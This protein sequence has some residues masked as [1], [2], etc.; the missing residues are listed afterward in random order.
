MLRLTS[1][2]FAEPHYDAVGSG[3]ID[4]R[5]AE[6]V[7]AVKACEGNLLLHH[8][9]FLLIVSVTCRTVKAVKAFPIRI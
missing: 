2:D 5:R 9:R 4:L 3:I 6:S 8:S 1:Q 7:K